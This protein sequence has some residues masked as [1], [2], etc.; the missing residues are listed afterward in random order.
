LTPIPPG[1]ATPQQIRLQRRLLKLSSYYAFIIGSLLAV[2][3]ERSAIESFRIE[4]PLF[5]ARLT[6]LRITNGDI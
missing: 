4:R 2:M 6:F 3:A 5:E 1:R